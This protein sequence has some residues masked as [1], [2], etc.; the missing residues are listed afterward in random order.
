MPGGTLPHRA[1]RARPIVADFISINAICIDA[2]LHVRVLNAH[3]H[4]G[5][6]PERSEA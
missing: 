4:M 1:E 2:A 5:P 3:S 6:Q